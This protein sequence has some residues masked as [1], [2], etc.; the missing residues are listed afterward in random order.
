MRRSD[1]CAEA[2]PRVREDVR[3]HSAATAVRRLKR[4]PQWAALL[5]RFYAR[6]QT[7]VPMVEPLKGQQ[8][9]EPYRGL[10][11]HSRD[12]TPTLEAFYEQA[13]GITVM[14][15]EI[16]AGNYWREVLL[17]TVNDGK[18]VE[19]GVIRMHLDHLPP[20][21]RRKVLAEEK[22]LGNILQT[23]GIPHLSWPQGFFRVKAD[24]HLSWVLRLSGPGFLY[25]RR[26]ILLDGSRRLLAEVIEVLPLA[27]ASKA[28]DSGGALED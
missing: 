13:L 6:L 17:T 7:P 3:F 15:R 19:Y 24:A 25:G 28:P 9:P 27:E 26:N 11:V 18:P 8:L 16:D 20:V 14:G 21:A 10:L 2:E 1:P 22:P 5:G 23:E 12:M 4:Q